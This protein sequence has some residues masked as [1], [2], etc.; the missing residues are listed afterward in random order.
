MATLEECRSALSR[1]SAAMGGLDSANRGHVLDRTVS[2]A[3]PDL[4]ITFSGRLDGAGF[5]DIST[6]PG[7][8]AQIRL[9]IGSDDL[10]ALADGQ[11][12]FASAWSRGRVKIDASF[13]DLLRLRKLF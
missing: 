13:G 3:V 11:L 8:R 2:C 5:H 12:N 6:D 4:G 10:V 9:T 1:L 7:P